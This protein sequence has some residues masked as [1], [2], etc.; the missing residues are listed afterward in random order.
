MC[1]NQ[2]DLF[3]KPLN[4]LESAEFLAHTLRNHKVKSYKKCSNRY[5][6]HEIINKPYKHYCIDHIID[7]AIETD[8]ILPYAHPIVSSPVMS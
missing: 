4:K 8:I 3:G 2:Q 7:E 1:S 6:K 5:C